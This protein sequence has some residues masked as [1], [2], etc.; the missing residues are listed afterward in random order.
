MNFDTSKK[1]ASLADFART[2][3]K[4][5]RAKGFTDGNFTALV[6]KTDALENEITTAFK[7]DK[8]PATLEKPDSE[9][10]ECIKT[11]RALIQA[12]ALHPDTAIRE[13][14][15]AAKTVF[16]KYGVKITRAKYEEESTY[17]RSLLADFDGIAA[18]TKLISGLDETISNLKAAEEKFEAEYAAYTKAVSSVGRNATA[19]KKELYT[20]LNS[21][22][23]P[24]IDAVSL[25]NDD[26]K[27]LQSELE[28]IL[29]RV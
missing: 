21:G 27:A 5:C 6:D 24:Y 10:D 12:A 19:I 28:T 11:I 26:Y 20:I 16:A 29:A 9:R 25:V 7:R 22:L 1:V 17:V 23:L 3:V 2:A 8:I 15:T 13:A 18:Q 14:G 4:L